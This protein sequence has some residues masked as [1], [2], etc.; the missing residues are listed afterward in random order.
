[1]SGDGRSEPGVRVHSVRVV[2]HGCS[3]AGLVAVVRVRAVV[4]GDVGVVAGGVAS[5]RRE[6]LN[7]QHVVMFC[8]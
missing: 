2:D 4:V 7:H 3:D 8:V 5:G 1:M 6:R